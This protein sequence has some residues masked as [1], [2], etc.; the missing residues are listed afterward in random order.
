[1]P[2]ALILGASSDMAMAIA[3]RFAANN[4]AVQLAG[5]HIQRMAAFQ[6]DLQIRQSTVCSLHEFD[7]QQYNTHA[8]F[9]E[10][11][12]PKP[13]VTICVFGVMDD[14]DLAFNDWSLTERMIN[15]NFTGAV[16]ILNIAA[17]HYISQKKGCIAGISSVAG[18]RG[19]Q[20]K[21]IYGSAKAAFTAYLDG[22]RNK[23]FKYG[24]HVITVKPGFVNTKMT[25][26]LK[27]PAPLTAQPEEV[28]KAIYK[29]VQKRT[30]TIYVKWIWRWIMLIIK[31][32]PEFQFKKMKL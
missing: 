3:R 28:A 20:S 1:M 14:E 4:Y 21:L 25:E 7:A 24:V 8:G 31:N 5:R 12:E 19:R 26:E 13:D 32:I 11:L 22:L 2:T 16:S 30:N 15:T 27:L 29:A 6:S 10:Q 18:E 17:Q 23:L 9:F